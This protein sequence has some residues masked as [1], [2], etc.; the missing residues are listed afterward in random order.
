MKWPALLFVP[1][2]GVVRA[3]DPP[4]P[5][6]EPR[7]KDRVAERAD[8]MREQI[9]KGRQV[10]SHVRVAVRL[11]NGNKLVGVVKDGRFVERVDGL[12]FVDAQ[13]KE[14]GAGIRLWYSGGTRNYVFVPFAHFQ[15]YEVLQRLSQ[16]QLTAMEQEMQMTEQ[17]A[18]E[19]AAAR[20]HSA[21][22]QPAE[23]APPA[24][25]DAPQTGDGTPSRSWKDAPP[26]PGANAADPQKEAGAG[27]ATG[28]DPEAQPAVQ[29]EAGKGDDGK[30]DGDKA[31]GKKAD[32]EK[33]GTRR[34]TAKSGAKEGEASDKAKAAADEQAQQRAW[35]QLLQKYPPKEGWNQ[36]KRD[37]I[38][39]RFVVVGAK[40]SEL[41]QQFVDQFAEWA[42]ACKH[43]GVDPGAAT[44]K[45]KGGDQGGGAG[46]G[47]EKERKKAR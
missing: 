43:F 33:P 29:G 10:K 46:Q 14:Q 6:V 8:N 21:T 16:E 41:E 44:D 35:F 22:G 17:R 32:G 37:E 31:D 42:K 13:A 19:R 9:D 34:R 45:D 18:A 24:T 25:P 3:Q 2:L 28:A 11:K 5:T 30:S 36:Q 23:Q 20:A 15:S 40:P 1:L 39:R 27:G 47:K 12:R 4:A 38:S 7:P 26:G